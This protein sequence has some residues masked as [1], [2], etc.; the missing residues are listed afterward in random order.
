VKLASDESDIVLKRGTLK[1]LVSSLIPC[2]YIAK[3]SRGFT[4]FTKIP[5]NATVR[6]RAV[7]IDNAKNRS[8]TP[9]KSRALRVLLVEDSELDAVLLCRALELGGFKVEKNRVCTPNDLRAALKAETWDLILAD[10]SMP[11]FSA[12]EALEIVAETGEDF[13][14][15]IVS[16]HI[17]E[18]TAVAAMRAGAHDYIMK[19][20]LGRLVPAVERE[21]RE[22]EVRRAR[23]A[24]EEALRGAQAELETRV[25]ER[26]LALQDANARLRQ[27]F[28][29]RKKLELELLEIAENERR[30][31]GLDLHD[32]LGQKLTG[33]CL[34]VKGLAQK[35]KIQGNSHSEEAHKI[36]A[37]V[38]EV[39]ERTH[40]IARQFSSLDAHGGN[41][42]ESLSHLAESVMKMFPVHCAF[43]PQGALPVL[44]DH[45]GVQLAKI[46]QEAVSN[47][48]K[49][50]KASR[51][52][53]QLGFENGVL[54]LL[55][56]NDGE[57]FQPPPP[58]QKRMGLRIM[59]YRASTL[60]GSVAIGPGEEGGACVTCTIPIA[61]L[62]RNGDDKT[63]KFSKGGSDKKSKTSASETAAV[64]AR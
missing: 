29:E 7:K 61:S 31:I 45:A 33:I 21:L 60:D 17:D 30:R 34:M 59:R 10:H 23:A 37:L 3:V 58:T 47:A 41:L 52:E 16:G 40:N 44:S 14:F 5:G 26:T 36:H 11:G 42:T 48:I 63:E 22:A 35:L 20:A 19:N 28:E 18:E 24:S 38:E 53:L 8:S 6:N 13:P 56:K 1:T 62:G 55:I 27:V 57:P 49:H 2:V 64:G 54:T 4:L 15:I 46:A 43:K 50:G 51:V 9:S 25:K 32:D 12:P 39:I